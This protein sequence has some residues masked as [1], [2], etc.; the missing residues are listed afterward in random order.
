MLRAELAACS[1]QSR[2]W[3]FAALVARNGSAPP[4][5]STRQAPV[6]K[7]LSSD[8]SVAWRGVSRQ[9]GGSREPGVEPSRGHRVGR[10]G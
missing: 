8:P 2:L 7:A 3:M 1:I 5:R 4:R 6:P 10:F 9:R